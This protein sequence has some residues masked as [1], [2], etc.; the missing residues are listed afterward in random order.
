MAR[1]LRRSRGEEERDGDPVALSGGVLLA[2][3]GC[4]VGT[5]STFDG[6]WPLRPLPVVLPTEHAR[7]PAGD[8]LVRGGSWP[9]DGDAVLLADGEAHS[10]DRLAGAGDPQPL[11]RTLYSR[12]GEQIQAR[13]LPRNG[14]AVGPP[15]PV[16]TVAGLRLYRPLP[17]G[18]LL[19][20]NDAGVL[21]IEGDRQRSIW[22]GEAEAVAW[23]A[24]REAAWIVARAP[25]ATIDCVRVDDGELLL[26]SPLPVELDSPNVEVLLSGGDA[27][28]YAHDRP[29]AAGLLI[30]P[31]ALAITTLGRALPSAGLGADPWPEHGGAPP[32][33]RVALAEG[34]WPPVLT[35]PGRFDGE[36]LRLFQAT[37]PARGRV[38]PFPGGRFLVLGGWE[39]EPWTVGVSRPRGSGAPRRSSPARSRSPTAGSRRCRPSRGTP[40][41]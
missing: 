3:T 20:A 31:D 39:L 41:A 21:L 2:L 35:P 6:D 7:G 8:A 26:R 1:R 10:L 22:R 27:V 30:S 29:L 15:Q 32:L 25:L 13:R 24:T 12:L 38:A 18:R 37:G 9:L 5:I 36:R 28:V 33:T 11:G 4:K 34:E 23:D 14:G 40:P 16:C 17:D 19:A